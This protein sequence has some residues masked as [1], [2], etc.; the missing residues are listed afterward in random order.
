LLKATQKGSEANRADATTCTKTQY[1]YLNGIY[2][3]GHCYSWV[4]CVETKTRLSDKQEEVQRFVYITN[5]EQTPGIAANTAD[6]GRLRWKIE[7]EG[8]NPDYS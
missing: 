1:R 5:I 3:E 2:Y 7:N 6:G 8:F 4:S